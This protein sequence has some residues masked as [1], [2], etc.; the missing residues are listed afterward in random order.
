MF[1]KQVVGNIGLKPGRKTWVMENILRNH[2][3]INQV[4]LNTEVAMLPHA[5][6]RIR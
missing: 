6:L 1:I 5:Q 4:I 3:Y 2:N